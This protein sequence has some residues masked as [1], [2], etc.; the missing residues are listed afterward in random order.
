MSKIMGIFGA[1]GGFVSNPVM[2]GFNY[3]PES[4]FNKDW[5]KVRKHSRRATIRAGNN[6]GKRR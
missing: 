4:D 6:Q 1:L 5:S 3:I 2:Q